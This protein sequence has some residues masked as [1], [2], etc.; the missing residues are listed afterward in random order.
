MERYALYPCP[1]KWNDGGKGPSLVLESHNLFA[2][3]YDGWIKKTPIAVIARS[4]HASLAAGFIELAR[5]LAGRKHVKHIALSG[6]CMQN[7]TLA[8]LLEQGLAA[9]GLTTL[10]HR[11]FPPGDACISLGQAAWGRYVLAGGFC[12]GR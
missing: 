1:V 6:G 2:S 8:F 11:H 9:S 7:M 12:Y 3:V 4:F 10:P 5:N